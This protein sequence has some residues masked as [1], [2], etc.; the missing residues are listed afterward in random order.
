MTEGIRP[1]TIE[2]ATDST[3]T[4]G[5][6]VMSGMSVKYP[7]IRWIFSHSGGTLPFLSGRFVRLAEERKPAHCRTGRCRIRKFYY[8]LA[9]GNTGGQIAALLKMVPVSQVLYGT[10]FPFRDGA[11]VNGGIADYGFKPDEIR[12]I[13]REVALKLIPRLKQG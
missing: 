11:E 5:Q 10:D 12:S 6:L 3:R 1:S 4:I 13:E 2:Y 7:D 9:Q 8:E